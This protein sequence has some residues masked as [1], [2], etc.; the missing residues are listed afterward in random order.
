MYWEGENVALF[1]TI[2]SG[3]GGSSWG[4]Y[5]SLV[6]GIIYLLFI[7]VI[8][9]KSRIILAV[10]LPISVVVS[11]ALWQMFG[12]SFLLLYA[13]TLIITGGIIAYAIFQ[14]IWRPT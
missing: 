14:I 6:I 5:S 13:L 1:E 4:I 10:G 3:L 9:V 7:A 11:Y 8:M 12:D 2:S